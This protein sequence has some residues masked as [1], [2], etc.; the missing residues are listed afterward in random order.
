[1]HEKL[2]DYIR[3]KGRISLIIDTWARNNELDYTAVT[4]YWQ[5][6]LG[7]YHLIL[8]DIIKLSEPIYNGYYFCTKL[9]EVTNRLGITCVVISIT[10]DN[11]SPINKMLDEFESVITS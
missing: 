2:Q 3:N 9:L 4:R 8:L 5:T 6:K 11:T 1:M 7:V 10:R